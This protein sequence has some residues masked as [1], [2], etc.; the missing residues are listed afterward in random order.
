[1]LIARGETPGLQDAQNDP[2]RV[3]YEAGPN[4]LVEYTM[5]DATLFLWPHRQSPCFVV[6]KD[7]FIHKFSHNIYKQLTVLRFNLFL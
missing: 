5:V 1:M 4:L 3:Q 7:P 2:E 6:N